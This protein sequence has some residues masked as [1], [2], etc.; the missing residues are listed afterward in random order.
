MCQTQLS[1]GWLEAGRE[2][3]WVYMSA[4]AASWQAVRYGVLLTSYTLSYHSGM[5]GDQAVHPPRYKQNHL[6][7]RLTCRGE[8][9]KTYTKALL[10]TRDS[11]HQQS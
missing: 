4:Q 7:S 6:N 1:E 3:R 5:T 8:M 11:V 10:R 9:S 2:V